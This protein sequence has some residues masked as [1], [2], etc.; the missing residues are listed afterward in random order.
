MIY[1]A[2]NVSITVPKVFYS[3]LHKYRAY[4]VM[5]RIQ[6][7]AIATVW[8]TLSEQSREKI[9]SQLK[10]FIHELRALKLT[11]GTILA[12]CVGGSVREARI[13]R[14]LPHMGPFKHIQ[15]FHL[16]LEIISGPKN[17]KVRERARTGS[18][19]LRWF[20]SRMGHGRRQSFVTAISV[21]LTFLFV[22]T[23]WLLS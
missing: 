13:P 23:R 12:N 17:P 6:G 11:D 4:I 1:V 5:K 3:F 22:D 10:H 8:K 9:F 15:E 21:H 18:S 2:E 14:A 19:L 16:F 7:K 20:P